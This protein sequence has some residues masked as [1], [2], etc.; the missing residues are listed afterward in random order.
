MPFVEHP[1]S[2]RT[3]FNVNAGNDAVSNLLDI[4]TSTSNYNVLLFIR[5]E[6]C[7]RVQPRQAHVK[8]IGFRLCAPLCAINQ[9]IANSGLND[10][11][12]FMF[13]TNVS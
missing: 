11:V 7:F 13:C 9:N 6:A 5:T 2:C 10:F 4:S 8:S 12:E 1:V 3:I